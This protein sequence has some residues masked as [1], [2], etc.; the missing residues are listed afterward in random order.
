MKRLAQ[1][2]QTNRTCCL[3]LLRYLRQEFAI[4]TAVLRR[5]RLSL[6]DLLLLSR[7]R[8][9]CSWRESHYSEKTS[10]IQ[11]FDGFT[12]TTGLSHRPGGSIRNS[13]AQVYLTAQ[14][15][16]REVSAV[17]DP[18][19]RN[20]CMRELHL[21]SHEVRTQVAIRTCNVSAQRRRTH[22]ARLAEFIPLIRALCKS[23][24][25]LPT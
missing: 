8:M 11:K 9:P 6:V 17:R 24:G 20:A 5:S 25:L 13:V 4:V 12:K 15:L 23:V 1:N 7:C 10:L 3:Q 18:E 22:P 16:F 19:Y 14:C 21:W 2:E